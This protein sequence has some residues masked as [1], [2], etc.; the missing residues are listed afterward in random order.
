MIT[1]PVGHLQRGHL[2]VLTKSLVMCMVVG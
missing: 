1:S 2:E